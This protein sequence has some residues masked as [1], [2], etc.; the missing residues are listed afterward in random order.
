MIGHGRRGKGGMS[1]YLKR[2]HLLGGHTL[3]NA[4][5]DRVY[6]FTAAE[7]SDDLSSQEDPA[8]LLKY[9]L[10]FEVRSSG[11]GARMA[12]NRFRLAGDNGWPLFCGHLL[13]ETRCR[14]SR[15]SKDCREHSN[16]A[17]V[18]PTGAA[19]V[20]PGDPCFHGGD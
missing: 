6:E 8:G 2:G 3:V 18:F 11:H 1:T 19:S 14:K 5:A 17:R 9:Q 16:D 15:A 12:V 10:D 20:G 7:S 4:D 13:V